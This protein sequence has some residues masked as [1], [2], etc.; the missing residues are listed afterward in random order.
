MIISNSKSIPF[1]SI[2]F[3]ARLIKNEKEIKILF[4]CDVIRQATTLHAIH[5]PCMMISQ[6]E[7]YLHQ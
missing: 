1:V 4:A 3:P 6:K 7:F 5:S 2:S